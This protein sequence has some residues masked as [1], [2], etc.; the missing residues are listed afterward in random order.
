MKGM[1]RLSES[2]GAH[3]NMQLL[4]TSAMP[5]LPCPAAS[6][7]SVLL[8]AGIAAAP[9]GVAAWQLFRLP[10]LTQ[11]SKK[12]NR[13]HRAAAEGELDKVWW[14]LALCPAAAAAPDVD[15]CLPIHLACQHGRPVEAVEWLLAAAPDTAAAVTAQGDTP[16]HLACEQSPLSPALVRLLLAAAPGTARAVDAGGR[17]PLHL[18]CTCE[19]LHGT[20]DAV[21]LLLGAAP[22]LATALDRSGQTPLHIAARMGQLAAASAILLTARAAAEVQSRA[23]RLPL[24]IACMA[25]H[26]NVAR[27]LL[28]AAP[29]TA[30]RPDPA[31]Q[32]PLHLAAAHGRASVVPLFSAVPAA[33]VARGPDNATP[34]YLAAHSG[35]AETVAALLVL[36]PAAA[37]IAVGQL[38]PIH[39]AAQRGHAAVTR[40][41][42]IAAPETAVV[43]GPERRTP[44]QLALAHQHLATAHCLLGDGPAAD[45]LRTLRAAGR[46]ALPLFADLVM[47]R[48]ALRLREW[49]LVPAPCPGLGRALPAA[50][51]HS[52]AHAAQLVAR[53]PEDDVARL[54]TA[55]LCLVR[56]QRTLGLPA[57]LPAPAVQRVLAACLG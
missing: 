39:V 13:L 25:G 22:G 28:A 3:G 33:A 56:L 11:D 8:R 1:Q 32:Q 37:G 26:V 23:G 21:E 41:L 35:H 14:L 2:S 54:R 31:G 16:L 5:P 17:T 38:L 9:A 20:A 40:L 42:C 15:G 47:A 29:Q 55:A 53:L 27:A 45:V 50:L 34:L 12:R 19:R 51:A 30:A 18:A 43:A 52:R 24:H 10:F 48:P 57:R 7:A 49:A 46:Q 44:L 36:A 4:V 6:A